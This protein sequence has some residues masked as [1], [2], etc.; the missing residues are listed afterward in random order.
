MSKFDN[1]KEESIQ[2]VPLII[3]STIAKF[4]IKEI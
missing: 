1:S 3:I 2:G 4:R